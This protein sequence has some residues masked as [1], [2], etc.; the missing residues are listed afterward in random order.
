M[1]EKILQ[2][3]S[4]KENAFPESMKEK[5]K[6]WYKKREKKVQHWLVDCFN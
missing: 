2:K 4:D 3:P 1:G 5:L 6:Y